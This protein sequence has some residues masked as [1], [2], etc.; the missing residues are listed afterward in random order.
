MDFQLLTKYYQQKIL[1]IT[2]QNRL[3]YMVIFPVKFISQ[4]NK[5]VK[6]NISNV[7]FN[8]QIDEQQIKDLFM[9]ELKC[10]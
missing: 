7:L 4:L 3:L 6:K 2:I 5:F 1:L 10:I 9:N 8:K